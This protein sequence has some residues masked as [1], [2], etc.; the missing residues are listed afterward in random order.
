MA[1]SYSDS[2]AVLVVITRVGITIITGI[3]S[4]IGAV[5]G[6]KVYIEGYG[7]V[8]RGAE[9]YRASGSYKAGY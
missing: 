4:I 1:V 3:T 2:G 6:I 7:A 5:T 9:G 8:Y